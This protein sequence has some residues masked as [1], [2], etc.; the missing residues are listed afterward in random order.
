[1]NGHALL[2]THVAVPFTLTQRPNL[3]RE[4]SQMSNGGSVRGRSGMV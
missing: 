1:M 3:H 4:M 2:Q